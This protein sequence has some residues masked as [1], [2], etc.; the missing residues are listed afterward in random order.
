[1]APPR[2]PR[3]ASDTPLGIDH[4][5]A[6]KTIDYAVAYVFHVVSPDLCRRRSNLRLGSGFSSAAWLVSVTPL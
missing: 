3:V 1:M 2:E 5:C 6:V 4:H